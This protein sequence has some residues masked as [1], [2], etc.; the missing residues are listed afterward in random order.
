MASYPVNLEV[1]NAFQTTLLTQAKRLCDDIA[2]TYSKDSKELW[3]SVKSNLSIGLMDIEVDEEIPKFCE[4]PLGVTDGAIRIRCRAPCVLG[5]PSCPLHMHKQSPAPQTD[6]E[7]VD[8]VFDFCMRQYFVDAKG[9]ARD[10]NGCVKGVVKDDVLFLF[11]K[12]I[13]QEESTE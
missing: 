2:R 7:S 5:F 6:I 9:V 13:E 8:R 3:N 12:D 10:K 1:W 11:E 4:F